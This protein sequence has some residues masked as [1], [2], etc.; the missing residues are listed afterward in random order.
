[1]KFFEGMQKDFSKEKEVEN[2]IVKIKSNFKDRTYGN[3]IEFEQ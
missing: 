2:G 1:M 3:F